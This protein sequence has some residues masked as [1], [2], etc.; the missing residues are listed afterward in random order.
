MPGGWQVDLV[1]RARASLDPLLFRYLT[2]GAHDGVSA[3]EAGWTDVRF[4]P[5]VLSDV[6]EV[7]LGGELLGTPVRAPWAIAPTSLQRA[8]HPDGDEAMA[9]ACAARGVLLVV[10]SNTGTP[11][12]AIGRTGVGWW[13]QVYLPV[14]RGLA[15]PLLERAASAGARAIVLTVDTPVVGT[16]PGAGPT[17]WDVVDPALVRVNFDPGYDDLPGAEKARDLG[18]DDIEWLA[19]RTGLPIVV[20]GVLRADDARRTVGAGASA[21]WVSNHGGRQLDRALRTAQ[22]LPSVAGEVGAAAPV[23]VDGGVRSGL[24]V[25]AGLALGAQAVFLGRLPILALADGEAGVGALLENLRAETEEAFRLAGCR[26]V[27]DT[28]GIAVA[29]PERAL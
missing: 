2:D 14:D 29:P 3:A 26:S 20:K 22:A 23:Y 18:P 24:D 10:S 9:R 25:L 1:E 21:V 12:D 4:A 19:A 15:L 13:L 27:A 8:V 17:V 7:E 16:K 5:H 6:T 28:P 11:F